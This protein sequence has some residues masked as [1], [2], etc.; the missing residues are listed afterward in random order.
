MMDETFFTTA[1]LRGRWFCTEDIAAF[2]AYRSDPFVARY[3]SWDGCDRDEA[4]RF[5]GEQTT[6]SFG[7]PGV[8]FQVAVAQNTDDA[9]IGDCY[10]VRDLNEPDV[11]EIGFT[12]ARAYHG[13]GFGAE[14]VLGL[15]T[16]VFAR[17]SLQRVGMRREACLPQNGFYKNEWCDEF[18]YAV[19]RNDWRE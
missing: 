18:V 15:L 4:R 9:P 2:Q 16:C 5:V 3:Q 6:L 1:R 17:F 14:A 11:A 13:R 10:F 8:G 7:A 19:S 12:L